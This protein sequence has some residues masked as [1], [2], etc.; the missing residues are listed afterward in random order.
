VLATDT[1]QRRA[2]AAGPSL[3]A[4][5]LGVIEILAARA[6]E[7]VARGRRLVAQLPRGAGQQR[8]RQHAIVAT[9]A[10]V[11]SQIGVAYQCADTQTAFGRSFDLVQ[12]Q[13]VDIYQMRWRFDL[14][15][16]QVQQIGAPGDELGAFIAHGRRGRFGGR[17]RAFV[18]EGFHARLPATSLIASTMLE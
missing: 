13:R 5:L 1:A 3:V 12:R 14:Q 9:Y 4:R 2:A 16:H 7:Q 15:L 11:G 6:L 17:I 8:T 10:R 18:A